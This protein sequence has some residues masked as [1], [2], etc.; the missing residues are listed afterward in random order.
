MGIVWGER[1]AVFNTSRLRDVLVRGRIADDRTATDFVEELNSQTEEALSAYAPQ[2]QVGLAF[3]RVLRAIAEAEARQARHL[4]RA[5][6][7]LLLGLALAVGIV[8]GVG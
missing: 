3:E 2:E 7:I 5:V 8:L 4:N 6:G 1:M